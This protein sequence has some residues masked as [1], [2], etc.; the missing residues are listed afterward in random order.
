MMRLDEPDAEA[1]PEVPI[2]APL[3]DGDQFPDRNQFIWHL[4]NNLGWKTGKIAAWFGLSLRQVQRITKRRPG[5][6]GDGMPEAMTLSAEEKRDMLDEYARD[7]D[8]R[9]LLQDLRVWLEGE[10]TGV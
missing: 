7:P 6:T 8:S 9:L 4:V 3:F 1:A 2:L 10:P 5:T